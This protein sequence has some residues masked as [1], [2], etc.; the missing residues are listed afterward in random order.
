MEKVE[1]KAPLKA[2]YEKYRPI[3]ERREEIREEINKLTREYQALEAIL[4]ENMYLKETQKKKYREKRE[5]REREE[6]GE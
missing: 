3:L 6:R 1:S 2:E 5:E 4:K